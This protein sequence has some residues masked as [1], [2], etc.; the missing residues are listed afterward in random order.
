MAPKRK[1]R[2]GA[3]IRP[4]KKATRASASLGAPPL[5]A[6]RMA[7]KRKA[8]G[9]APIRPQKKATQAS[10]SLGAPPLTAPRMAPKRKA[11]GGAPIRP[12]KKA[13]RASASLGAPPL[14][15]SAEVAFDEAA[16]M[17]DILR[18]HGPATETRE[19]ARQTWERSVEKRLD[20]SSKMICEMH[21]MLES[22]LA[23]RP[24]DSTASVVQSTSQPSV[25]VASVST[26]RATASSQ[27]A[28]NTPPPW[29][30]LNNAGI[31]QGLP[32]A[33]QERVA[34]LTA[35]SLPIH[36]HVPEKIKAK[37]WADEYVPF[38]A[39]L[40]SNPSFRQDYSLAIQSTAD[41]E[42]VLRVLPAAQAEIRSFY[43]WTP[44]F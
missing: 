24:T 3:P 36:I 44:S 35:P 38:S 32:Y 22:V 25:A 7:P 18:S 43:Q 14:T 1:A 21:G 41:T 17:R 34:T 23:N 26:T 9:G 20:E 5:T 33:T 39:L 15:A 2:G 4:Q 31:I 16:G 13:T 12:Q 28:D 37:I 8:R 19:P 29:P 11:R 6:P 42:P 30:S 10:A 40:K 27:D